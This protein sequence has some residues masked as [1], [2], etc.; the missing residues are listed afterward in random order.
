MPE[1]I[2]DFHT[3]FGPVPPRAAE[4]GTARLQTLLTQHGVAG[5]VAL[6]TRGAYHNAHAGNRETLALCQQSG[7][8]LIP[9]A[10]LDPRI[11]K[12][13]QAIGGAKVF[14]LLPNTQKWPMPFAPVCDVL[15]DLMKLGGDATGKIP[16][17]WE[18][19]R[20]GDATQISE[21]LTDT[22]YPAPVV[23]GGVTGDTL[24]ESMAIARQKPSVYLSTSR[25]R[26]IGDI[27]LIAQTLGADRIIFASAAPARSLGAV[28]SLIEQAGLS[29]SDTD[30]VLGGNARRLLGMSIAQMGTA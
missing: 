10:V 13:H 21:I 2:F 20:P 14:C 25:L 19:T 29:E 7:G 17:W 18:A 9:A 8:V 16:L 26:G 1:P 27:A 12:P 30:L 5:A 23:L 22:H 24:V 15:E 28:L 6:S 4:P 3:L 11:P